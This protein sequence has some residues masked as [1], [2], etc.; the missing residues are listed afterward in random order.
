MSSIE[1]TA[2]AI[3][4]ICSVLLGERRRTVLPKETKE[5]LESVFERKRCPNAKERRAI[6]EKCGLTPIQIRI[7][8]TNKRMRSKTRGARF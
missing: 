7:W 3:Q 6:A 1:E 2:Q 4:A 5:F 8:F